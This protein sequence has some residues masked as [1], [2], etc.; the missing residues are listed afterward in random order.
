MKGSPVP[1]GEGGQVGADA[2]E[3]VCAFAFGEREKKTPLAANPPS[4]PQFFS[5]SFFF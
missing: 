5:S 3:G 1:H 2:R 4:Q